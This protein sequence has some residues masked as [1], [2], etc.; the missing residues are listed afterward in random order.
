[1][2]GVTDQVVLHGEGDRLR[3]VSSVQ[4]AEDGVDVVVHGVPADAE[5]LSD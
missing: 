5:L 4:L 2:S 3:L 1:M